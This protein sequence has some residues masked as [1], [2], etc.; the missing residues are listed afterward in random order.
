[1]PNKT[2]K[3]ILAIIMWIVGIII[4][5]AVGFGLISKVLAIPYIPSLVLIIVGWI[6]VVSTVIGMIIAIVN[7]FN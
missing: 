6:A 1:M 3:N 7:Y 5:L 4:S 2:A